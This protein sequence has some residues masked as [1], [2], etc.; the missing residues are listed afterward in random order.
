MGPLPHEGIR[1]A[2]DDDDGPHIAPPAHGFEKLDPAHSRHVDIE[3]QAVA[4][5]DAISG[6]KLAAKANSR[7]S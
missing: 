7:V 2:A 4:V 5:R 6:E 1:E 3:D